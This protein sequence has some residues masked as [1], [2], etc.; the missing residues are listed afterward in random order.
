MD[1]NGPALAPPEGVIPNLDHPE[2]KNWLAWFTL[3]LFC[4]VSTICVFVRAYGRGVFWGCLWAS[5]SIIYTPGYYVHQWNVR[6][7]DLIPLT[8]LIFVQGNTYCVVLMLLKIAILVEWS[9]ILV[10]KGN[11]T[12]SIFWWSC[13][14][15]IAVQLGAGI[16]IVTALNLQCIP[17]VAS[18]DFRIPGK[19]FPL[20]ALQLSSGIIYLASDIIMFLLPQRTI[21]GLK[22]SMQK[23]LGVSV[24]FG[25]GLIACFAAVFRLQVTVTYGHTTDATYRAGDLIFW[26]IA[27]MTCGFFVVCMPCLPKILQDTG[28]LRKMKRG[29]STPS[30][31]SS[32]PKNGHYGNSVGSSTKMP[33]TTSNA[34]RVLD[35]DTMV[36]G[37]LKA[38]ESTEKLRQEGYTGSTGGIVRTTRITVDGTPQD[39]THSSNDSGSYHKNS[40]AAWAV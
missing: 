15:M 29:F 40:K 7:G 32:A 8:Y 31:G 24:V 1:L 12:T 14:V 2:N 17:H 39:D 13:M 16:S 10:P 26:A 34:Y 30:G 11:R 18:W 19:C 6:L 3:L 36:M 22:M 20:Y 4:V 33:S 28:I 21:W 23:R 37:N 25:L 35:E 5:F 27:E 38:S 9:R